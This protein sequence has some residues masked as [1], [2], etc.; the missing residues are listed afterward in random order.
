[1]P[2]TIHCPHS[3][4]DGFPV[5][6]FVGDAM[7][8]WCDHCKTYHPYDYVSKCIYW[9]SKLRRVQRV[10]RR[11]YVKKPPLATTAEGKVTP[12][13]DDKF[14]KKYPTVLE[15]LTDVQWDDGTERERSTVS[16]FIE[17]G[18]FKLALN[19]KALRRSLY[20]TADTMEAAFSVLERSLQAPQADWRGWNAKT[21][22]KA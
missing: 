5:H 8:E 3:I 6:V 15:Y 16:L 21:K 1:M 20:V 11:P 4:V 9:M 13:T 19:D 17:D 7:F 10:Y 14:A 18:A 2:L 12:L 22:K